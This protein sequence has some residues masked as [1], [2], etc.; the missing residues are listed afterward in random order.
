MLFLILPVILLTSAGV[1]LY[2]RPI[3]SSA[4][5]DDHDLAHV[6]DENKKQILLRMIANGSA[7]K[8]W[9]K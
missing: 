5:T 4:Q 3:E 7:V 8:S 6:T 9:G 1:Y 2:N